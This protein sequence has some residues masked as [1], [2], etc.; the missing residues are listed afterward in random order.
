M[1]T[2][3]IHIASRAKKGNYRF[4]VNGKEV[5]TKENFILAK[6]FAGKIKEFV[7]A[8]QLANF[9]GGYDFNGYG[10]A[11][12]EYHYLLTKK[13]AAT[14]QD[15]INGN[16][17]KATTKKTDEEKKIAWAKRLAKLAG[18]TIEEAA[19]I[20]DEKL[21]DKE[22]Q[23]E[24]LSGRQCK[25]GY[26]VKRERLINSVKRTNPLRRISDEKHAH[27]ILAA[28]ERHNN[29]TYELNLRLLQ[30]AARNGLCDFEDVREM[31]RAAARENK[32]VEV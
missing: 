14:L 23:I 29:T 12:Y 3:Y 6:R 19:I 24:L 15:I 9:G 28:S 11:N 8:R 7:E 31:A 25:Y 32:V 5:F 4:V 20:A 1:I 27:A 17:T 10:Y 13:D 30:D 26:S 2:R 21:A 22:R 18:I 16:K